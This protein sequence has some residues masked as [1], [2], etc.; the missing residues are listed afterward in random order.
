MAKEVEPQDTL[1]QRACIGKMTAF[2]QSFWHRE[3]GWK[4]KKDVEHA[5]LRSYVFNYSCIICRM[6]EVLNHTQSI[7]ILYVTVCSLTS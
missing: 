1:S 7:H 5:N 4:K 3:K 2:M 6:I